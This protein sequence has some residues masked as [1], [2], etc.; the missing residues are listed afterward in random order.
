MSPR[1]S[2]FEEALRRL[3]NLLTEGD[4]EAAS[5]QLLR[6]LDIC[7]EWGDEL[8]PPE[9]LV[10]CTAAAATCERLALAL[11]EEANTELQRTANNRRAIDRYQGR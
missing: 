6:V 5:Q 7:G 4:S 11:R 10:R 2:A 1:I 3:E 8:L 9:T